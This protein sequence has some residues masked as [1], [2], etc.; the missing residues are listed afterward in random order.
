MRDFRKSRTTITQ[1][2]LLEFLLYA[3]V[4]R[5]AFFLFREHVDTAGYYLQHF[6][7]LLTWAG[8]IL[9]SRAYGRTIKP[10]FSAASASCVSLQTKGRV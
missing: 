1:K 7:H 9:F 5:P 10:S 4:V 6:F 3:A 2:Q 8:A